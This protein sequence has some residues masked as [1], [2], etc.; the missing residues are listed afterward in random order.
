MVMAKDEQME[1]NG[2]VTKIKKGKARLRNYKRKFSNN[3]DP[4][5]PP[6]GK[7][8]LSRVNVLIGC[9]NKMTIVLL[10]K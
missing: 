7:S 1:G 2:E 6:W 9:D 5:F 10:V 8:G 3:K 4:Q